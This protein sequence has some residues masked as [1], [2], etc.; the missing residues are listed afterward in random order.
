MTTYGPDPAAAVD[1]QIVQTF[2]IP[3]TEEQAYTAMQGIS[4]GSFGPLGPTCQMFSAWGIVPSETNTLIYFDQWE[5]GYEDVLTSPTQSTTQVWGDGNTNNGIPPTFV[6]DYVNAG[7]YVSL[8]NSMAIPRNPAQIRYDG[9]DKLMVTKPIATTR[10]Q[11]AEDPG[12]VLSGAAQAPDTSRYGTEFVSP[13]GTDTPANDSFG[14]CAMTVIASRDDTLV[15]FDEDADGAVDR[16]VWLNQGEVSMVTNILAGARV[17][18]SK[19]VQAHL[20]TGRL[21]SYYQMRWFMLFP[22]YQWDDTYYAPVGS[23][24]NADGDVT[25]TTVYLYNP[26]ASAV[27]VFYTNAVT[28]GSTTIAARAT[29]YYDM[30]FDTGGKFFTT[31]GSQF[32]A[33]AVVDSGLA[34]QPREWGY[35][36]MPADIMAMM[37]ICGW[38]QG[39]GDLTQNGNPVWVSANSNATLYVDFDSN[40][41]TGSLTDPLG[42]KYD[43]ATNVSAFETAIV[44]DYVN[45]DKDQTATRV[46]T[47]SNAFIT[48]AW[49]EDPKTS[50]PGNPYLDMGCEILTFPSVLTEKRHALYTDLNTNGYTDP[51]DSVEYTIVLR[52]VGWMNANNVTIVDVVPTNTVYV[53]NSTRTNGVP[54]PDNNT[55]PPPPYTL[56]PLDEGGHLWGTLP[57]GASGT[58]SYVV[59]IVS[60][61]PTNDDNVVA[62]SAFVSSSTGGARTEDPEPVVLPGL[63]ITK[64]S[65]ASGRVAP[66]SNFM[67]SIVVRNTGTAAQTM[68][69]IGDLLPSGLDYVTN[70]TQIYTPF[71]VTNT[72]LDQFGA[73]S[74]GNNNGTASWLGNWVEAGE[75][76]GPSAGNVRVANVWS[77]NQL[78][79]WRTGYGAYRA[80]NTR[81]N[82]G[83][84]TNAVLS[85]NFRCVGLDAGEWVE[86]DARNDSTSA[87]TRLVA[88][89]NRRDAATQSTNFNITAFISTNTQVRFYAGNAGNNEGLAVDNVQIAFSGLRT[90]QGAAPPTL[91]DGYTLAS[92]QAL[93]VTV[94]VTAGDLSACTQLVNSAYALSAEHPARLYAGVTNAVVSADLAVFKSVSNAGPN[95]NELFS[96]RIV[97][98][99]MG[100]DT[101]TNITVADVLPAGVTYVSYSAGQG[102]YDAVSGV[103]TAGTVVASNGTWLSITGRVDGG[104][105]GQ[106]ITNRAVIARSSLSDPVWT[107]NT[108]S[109][110]ITVQSADL[111][112]TKTV[113]NPTPATNEVITFTVVLTNLGPNAATTVRVTDLLPAGLTYVGHTVSSGAYSQV[114]GIWTVGTVSAGASETLSLQARVNAGTENQAITNWAMVTS[115]DQA[116]PDPA[117]DSAGAI[118]AISGLDV[119]VSKA[120]D[121]PNPNT[122]DV[123]VYTIRATNYGPTAASGLQFTDL[124]PAGVTYSGHGSSAGAYD[125][126]SGVWDIGNLSSGAVVTLVITARVDTGTGGN[127]IT[128][129]AYLSA[130]TQSD[131]NPDNNASSAVLVVQSADLAVFKSV[132]KSMAN[133]LDPVT[134]TIVL[135]NNG[136]SAAEGVT[137][138]DLLPADVAYVSDTPSQGVYDPVSGIWTVGTVTACGYATLTI[139]ATVNAGTTGRSVSNVVRTTG[140]QQYDPVS[141]NN[142]STGTFVVINAMLEVSKQS[143]PAES[144]L[145]FDDVITY[146]LTVTSSGNVTQT[147][148]TVGDPSPSGSTYVAGSAT[149]TAP[150][151]MT[152]TVIDRFTATS[153]GNNDGTTNWIANWDEAGTDDEDPNTGRIRIYVTNLRLEGNSNIVRRMANTRGAAS[154][155]ISLI[156]RRDGLDDANDWAA[157]EISSNGYGGTWTQLGRYAGPATEA[158]FTSTNY[159]VTAYASTNMA[160]RFRC[161][162]SNTMGA[163]DYVYLD[164][165]QITYEGRYVSTF[166]GSD[167]PA[168]A[169]GFSLQTGE[170]MTAVFQVAVNDPN[171]CTQIFNTVSVTSV[172]HQAA[173]QASATDQVAKADLGV[174]KTVNY[175]TPVVG[176]ALDYTIVLTN[177]GPNAAKGAKITDVLPVQMVFSNATPSQGAYDPVSGIWTVGTVAAEA[178]ATLVLRA[179]LTNDNGGAAITNWASITGRKQIEVTGTNDTSYAV[180]TPKGTLALIRALRAHEEGGQVVVEWETSAEAG[181][182]GFFL[183]RLDPETGDFAAVNERIVPGLLVEPQG[184]TYRL[185]D[186]GAEPGGTYTYRLVEVEAAG[187]RH[188]YGPFCVTVSGRCSGAARLAAGGAGRA[189][190]WSRSARPVGEGKKARVQARRAQARAAAGERLAATGNL[191]KIYTRE[192]GLHYVSAAELGRVLGL[193]STTVAS[194][195]RGHRLQMTNRGSPVTY[196]VAGTGQGLYFCAEALTSIYTDENVYW[197]GTGRNKP[198]GTVP[199]R[200]APAVSGTP[201]FADASHAESNRYAV[202]TAFS[203][204]EEDVWMWQ[205]LVA[206]VPGFDT[207]TYAVQAPGAASAGRATVRANLLGGSR[208]GVAREHHVVV[209]VNGTPVG[210]GY[211][212]GIGRFAVS[213]D[214]NQA[215]LRDGTN[216]VEVKAVLDSGAPYSVVYVDSFDLNYRRCYRAFENRLTAP[217]TNRVMTISGFANA[218]ISVVNIAQPRRPVVVTGSRIEKAGGAYRVSFLQVGA[219]ARY[220]AFAAGGARKPEAVVAAQRTQLTSAANRANYLIVTVNELKA[221]AQE[222]ADYRAAQGYETMVVD[223]EAVYDVFNHGIASPFAL[224]DF[225]RYAWT[226]WALPPRYV[227]LAGEGTFDYKN[228]LGFGDNLLPAKVVPTP[229]GLFESDTWYAD[230][231]GDDGVPEIALGRLP[232]MTAEELQSQVDKIGAY[233][234]AAGDWTRRVMMVADNPDDAGDFPAT[235]DEVGALVP[236]GYLKERIYLPDWTVPAARTAIQ[237]G[238]NNGALLFNYI[239]HGAVEHLAA[240]VLLATNDVPLLVNGE[241]LPVMLGMTCYAGR[242]SLPG[243]DCLGECLVM[244]P[245][246]GTVGVWAPTGLSMNHLAVWLDQGFFSARFVA[247]VT[248]LGDLILSASDYYADQGGEQ[249]M[250][251]IYNLLGDPALIVK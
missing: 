72:V 150:V 123:I 164:D 48:T 233:E 135:T 216:T 22:S 133:E 201:T 205:Y 163:G 244:S 106:T 173:A 13:V 40:P 118:I 121:N 34:A 57:V 18:A 59:T 222:L 215:L 71:P 10:A 49:G 172:Q 6:V 166:P 43:V 23:Y 193:S 251:Y 21:A 78:R 157:L 197:I 74:Y 8:T 154:I 134:Y 141:T 95:T 127:A 130:L 140:S 80:A 129:R 60:P 77:A 236:G 29:G 113:N 212:E 240:E 28:G 230:V 185:L 242:Y 213:V 200:S 3:I 174:F 64:S 7:D 225:L 20:L 120:V 155:Q 152:N 234:A 250:L 73:V 107:N 208:T 37:A 5:D 162:P 30:P 175:S 38:G 180:I 9:R 47:L 1:V 132:D 191:A 194:L 61:F 214:F 182:V 218:Q 220:A 41:N 97:L 147:G 14:Y 27:R 139:A 232:V 198:A 115:R 156:F 159:D 17:T 177:N 100:P 219:G 105:A 98:T 103:W 125:N 221:A 88:W 226:Y 36:L 229:H 35:S 104:T 33:L 143:A 45:G 151:I 146:T 76:D 239:G 137:A 183:Q 209:S 12:Q 128:N 227:V 85:F 26:N 249:Y 42:R 111:G 99:N 92:G 66:G 210:G 79:M 223:L 189:V 171:T 231:E 90:D 11:Y 202:S 188:L 206:S 158:F 195:I 89:T 170:V 31:N 62:N 203:D 75:S 179:K 51:G 25:P 68:V 55:N 117:N 169:D 82:G 238:V 19:P 44:Y 207:G 196:V 192:T 167:P 241:K 46:Y 247:G 94:Q 245:V 122:N 126:G 181:T 53:P 160:I 136:P 131:F 69:R 84:Y 246:G 119:G 148:L 187:M 67:Y 112:V 93:T 124:L 91:A 96:Y 149:V 70:S 138:T 81:N 145:Y 178:Y 83:V 116:D 87:W 217:A 54:I 32:L 142:V 248:V 109:V 102:A 190:N 161:S 168:L 204:P 63:V 176:A 114:S 165:V 86:V 58:V 228:Y 56:F 110:P 211:S 24:T 235:S 65:S 237:N 186:P 224:R 16:S 108:S 50:L 199:G 243:F 15:R 2:F 101:A 52:N 184:G 4:V 153:Y 39:S 144:P